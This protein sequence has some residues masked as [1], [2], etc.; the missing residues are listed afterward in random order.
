MEYLQEIWPEWEFVEKIGEGAYGKVYKIRK[1]VAGH[2][3]FAALKIIEFPQEKSEV[4]E[5]LNSGMDYQS[6]RAYYEELKKNLINEIQIME[7]LKTAGNIVSIEDY[8]FRDNKEEVGCAIY[9]RMELLESLNDYMQR[10]GEL[11]V[12]EIVKIGTDLCRALE[13]CEQSKIIHRDMKPDNVFR[14]RYGDYKLGDFGISK[15]MEVTKSAYSQKGTSMY[16]APEIYRGEH[17]DHTVDI[18]SLGIMLY[19]LLNHGRFP[20]MPSVPTALRPSDAE[21][22]LRK[23]LSGETLPV[24]RDASEDMMKSILKACAFKAEERYQ[25]AV[26]FRKALENSVS[27]KE[28]QG[29]VTGDTEEEENAS[30]EKN[31]QVEKC[32][33]VEHIKEDLEK[34]QGVW[35]SEDQNYRHNDQK[36][37]EQVKGNVVDA[38]PPEKVVVDKN[39]RKHFEQQLRWTVNTDKQGK[40]EKR[41]KILLTIHIILF[42]WWIGKLFVFLS[43]TSSWGGGDWKWYFLHASGNIDPISLIVAS[44][45]AILICWGTFQILALNRTRKGALRIRFGACFIWAALILNFV[46]Y[47]VL[48]DYYD[49][50]LGRIEFW[51]IPAIP[52]FVYLWINNGMLNRICKELTDTKEELFLKELFGSGAD[53]KKYKIFILLADLIYCVNILCVGWRINYFFQIIL[54]CV[55][56]DVILDAFVILKKGN[57]YVPRISLVIQNFILAMLELLMFFVGVPT[58]GRIVNMISV[59]GVPPIDI[60][61][62]VIE[63]AYAFSTFTILWNLWKSVMIWPRKAVKSVGGQGEEKTT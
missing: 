42:C 38:A 56:L 62:F 3:S 43:R 53:N 29:Q 39:G 52:Y 5:L 8:S 27:L 33:Q 7:S 46:L 60:Y 24:L 28:N 45:G 10:A 55:I 26:E 63:F 51:I 22:A 37:S 49:S 17:Y 18:Y 15:Q 21:E 44:L 9:M 25:K 32:I 31:I 40:V 54:I 11:S 14:N 47:H 2:V 59:L 61:N 4:R 13:C 12:K 19:R 30:K 57:N 48:T 35:E 16:M 20:F 36:V 23:R 1:E 41:L 6:I 50:F 34:T 58:G